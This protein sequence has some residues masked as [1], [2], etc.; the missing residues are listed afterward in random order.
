MEGSG[1]YDDGY[2]QCEC[3]WGK[4]PGSLIGTLEN[5]RSELAAMRVWDIGCGEGKN[6]IYLARKGAIVDAWDVSELA[7]QNGKRAWRDSNAVNWTLGD[8]R[9][10]QPNSE[11]YDLVVMYGLLH[12]LSDKAEVRLCVEKSMAA[13]KSGGL[14]VMVA[15]NRRQQELDAHPG[16][17]PTLL[18]HNEYLELYS[19]WQLLHATDSDLHETH[20]HNGIAHTHSMTRLIAEKP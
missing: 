11:H 1:G 12:C 16:F 2:R 17:H 7:I 6:A 13:T 10:A 18:S 15:F 14:H 20:P 4:E 19:G 5:Y 8:I 9:S 3:F